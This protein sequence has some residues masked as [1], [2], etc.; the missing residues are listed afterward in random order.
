MLALILTLVLVGVLLYLAETY[1]PMS[2][3]IKLVIR[4][5][6]ILLLVLWLAQVF[7]L[8]DIPVPRVR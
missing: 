1:I 5:V 6:V 8:T 2:P 4:I 7:G 3:P